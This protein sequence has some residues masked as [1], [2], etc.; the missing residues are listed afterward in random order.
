[1]GGYPNLSTWDYAETDF[2]WRFIVADVT[3]PI[4]GDD[5][6][7][8]TPPPRLNNFP[9]NPRLPYHP[10]NSKCENDPYWC[11]N[12]PLLS[13]FVLQ[14]FNVKSRHDTLHYTGT[15]LVD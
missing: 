13:E 2:T 8:T 15:A 11:S 4:I 9:E 14:V 6:L 7:Q 3:H 10:A 5:F 1:M 12:R